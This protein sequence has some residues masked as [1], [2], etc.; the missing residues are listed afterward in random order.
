MALFSFLDTKPGEDFARE[1]GQEF[2][3]NC[4]AAG[5]ADAKREQ[6]LA[7]AVEVLANRAAKFDR[8]SPLGWYRKSKFMDAVK[9]ELLA[10][11]HDAGTVDRAVFAAVLRMARPS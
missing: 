4:P 1:I 6:R 7:H 5:K 2:A 9:R 10:H 8:Q 3:H 11:G